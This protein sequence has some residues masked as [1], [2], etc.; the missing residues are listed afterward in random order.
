MR[1]NQKLTQYFTLIVF[2][3]L[4]FGFFIFYFA[5]ERATTQS[6]I[7]KLE[8]LNRI[9]EK[10]LET[11]SIDQ[12]QAAHPYAKIRKL[13]E[14]QKDLVKEVIKEGEYK[15]NEQLQT[16]VNQVSVTTYPFVKNKHYEIHSQI[17]LTIIDNEYFLGIVM[18][19][20]WILVFIIISI[21]FFGELITRKLYT[22]FFNLVKQME[23]YDVRDD[24][25]QLK[26]IPSNIKELEQLNQLFLKSSSQSK[27]HY[28]ALKEFT[29]NLSHELQT[30]IANIKGKIELMLNTNLSEDQMIALSGMY[31]ELNKVSTINRSL[32][33]LMSLEHHQLTNERI[34]LTLLI[35]NIIA[36]HED[37]IM[38]N[39]VN[40]TLDLELDVYIKLNS[41]L[42]QVVFTNL[43][44]NAN[45]HNVENG[46]IEI[47]LNRKYFIIRNTGLEQEFTN[48]TIFQRFKKSKHRAESI[49]IGLAL[50]KKILNLYNFEI[51]YRFQQNWHQFTIDLRK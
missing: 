21:I 20:A 22:P 50:V 8:N 4:I 13:Q 40:F 12:I 26:I 9:I 44:S 7:G 1:L 39:G 28:D 43:V 34:N 10:K 16:N 25:Q 30:P 45:R 36:E 37:L 23:R 15:W 35:K 33:L 18:V 2:I 31:D 32:V 19:V 5:V 3:S 17:N 38:M 11:Q 14:H 48:E 27:S 47:I 51:T 29:E 6:A 49:G 42:A 46:L 41:M 24:S